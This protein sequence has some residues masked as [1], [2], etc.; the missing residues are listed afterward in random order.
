MGEFN[1][2]FV[3]Y[4]EISGDDRVFCEWKKI[5]EKDKTLR[6]VIDFVK[7]LKGWEHCILCGFIKHGPEISDKINA[8][9]LQS[10]DDK[11]EDSKRKRMTVTFYVDLE[12]QETTTREEFCTVIDTILSDIPEHTRKLFKDF[13]MDPETTDLVMDELMD[14]IMKNANLEALI[15]V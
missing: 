11:K 9:F 10:I 7:S 1:M 8:Y 6:V 4:Y 2:R 5:T 13:A 12:H 3:M 15:P 14:T